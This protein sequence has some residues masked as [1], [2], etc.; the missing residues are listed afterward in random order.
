MD[1]S[2]LG[3]TITSW[4]V[5]GSEPPS[6]GGGLTNDWADRVVANGG[7]TPST[8]TQAAINTFYSGLDASGILSKMI[9]VNCFAPD[10]LIAALTPLIHVYG[11]DP[12]T[13]SGFSSADLNISGLKGNGSGYLKLGVSGSHFW[14]DSESAGLTFMISQGINENKYDFGYNIGGAAFELYGPQSSTIYFRCWVQGNCDVFGYA[15][16]A[17]PPMY[18]CGSR[19]AANAIAIYRGITGEH[20]LVDSDTCKW[21]SGRAAEIF[22]YTESTVG[23]GP[24][25]LYSTKRFSFAAVHSGLTSGESAALYTLVNQMR[26][27]FGAG[28]V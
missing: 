15:G 10:S 14:P 25:G 13:N 7:A 1:A 16:G 28:Y 21:D 17:F 2:F 26:S 23:G 24:A 4:L 19:T 5:S 20:V 11:N 8:G 9:S 27:G 18:I 6:G 22:M 3:A 12:W